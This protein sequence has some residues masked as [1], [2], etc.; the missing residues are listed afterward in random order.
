MS[1]FFEAAQSQYTHTGTPETSSPLDAEAQ[2][3]MARY[4]GP[5]GPESP[6][7]PGV[8]VEARTACVHGEGGRK[9]WRENG[10][11]GFFETTSRGAAEKKWRGGMACAGRSP[12]TCPLRWGCP[13]RAEGGAQALPSSCPLDAPRSQTPPEKVH[14]EPSVPSPCDPRPRRGAGRARRGC[15]P[16]G[17][18]PPAIR[19]SRGQEAC[20]AAGREVRGGRCPYRPS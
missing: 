1:S 5:I 3:P 14:V 13:C 20:L 11:A 17:P 15:H 4:V 2:F 10:A 7:R 12:H 16:S 6:R 9:R 19:P 8:L 18:P